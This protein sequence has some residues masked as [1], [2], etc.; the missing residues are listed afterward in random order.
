MLLIDLAYTGL[1][2]RFKALIRS[3]N[4]QL[5]VAMIPIFSTSVRG[6]LA[7]AQYKKPAILTVATS[8]LNRDRRNGQGIRTMIGI[9]L[10]S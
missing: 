4:E 9:F 10:T 2:E 1:R 5:V 8:S 6:T 7:L 3:V